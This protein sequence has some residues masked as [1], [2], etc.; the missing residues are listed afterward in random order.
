M[1]DQEHEGAQQLAE[2]SRVATAELHK[3]GTPE[4]DARAHERA[5]EFE[6]KAADAVAARESQKEDDEPAQA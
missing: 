3:Q 4:Y 6:R 5:V 2:A 1:T